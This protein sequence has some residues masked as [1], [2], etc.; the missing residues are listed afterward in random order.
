MFF[1]KKYSL[2]L[3]Q[4]KEILTETLKAEQSKKHV[5]PST[6][7]ESVY[8]LKFDYNEW[9]ISYKHNILRGL[10]IKPDAY[11][12]LT[13]ISDKMTEMNVTFKLSPIWILAG[14]FV[15]LAFVALWFLPNN[16]PITFMGKN[17]GADW[18]NRMVII[19][20]NLALFNGVIWIT[21]LIETTRLKKVI[22]K[23]FGTGQIV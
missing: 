4:N 13:T 16:T 12:R 1:R 10:K 21:F 6:F 9:I 19:L 15:Q 3:N 20:C 23:L 17:L 8:E 11:I 7:S 14:I 5:L 2:L 18:L 22:E